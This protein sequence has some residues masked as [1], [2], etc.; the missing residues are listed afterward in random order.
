MDK[1]VLDKLLNS[2]KDDKAKGKKAVKQKSYREAISSFYQVLQTTEYLIQ[3][4]DPELQAR[5]E[6]FIQEHQVSSHMEVAVCFLN[7]KMWK[8]TIYHCQQT[9][10]LLE[11]YPAK[12]NTV[13]I[14]AYRT[15]ARAA[16]E[17]GEFELAENSLKKILELKP[18]DAEIESLVNQAQ[19]K[20]EESNKNEERSRSGQSV[21]RE[22]IEATLGFFF[23]RL[24]F[25]VGEKFSQYFEF[26]QLSDPTDAPDAPKKGRGC[27]ATRDIPPCTTL[28]IDR[29]I[30]FPSDRCFDLVDQI[31]RSPKLR[32]VYEKLYPNDE[33]PLVANLTN[34][35]KERMN[36]LR[37]NLD[38]DIRLRLL[39]PEMYD[40]QLTER[41]LQRVVLNS[42]GSDEMEY[43]Y[44]HLSYFNHSCD[45]NALAYHKG[46]MCL[47]KSIKP[48]KKGEEICIMYMDFNDSQWIRN[49]K[50]REHNFQCG[51]KRCAGLGEWR[52]KSILIQG[53]KCPV[54]KGTI[55]PDDNGDFACYRGC[56]DITKFKV[57]YKILD[58]NAA[59]DKLSPI[60]DKK[61]DSDVFPDDLEEEITKILKNSK[62]AGLTASLEE[63]QAFADKTFAPLHPTKA[64]VL[65]LLA[66]CYYTEGKSEEFNKTYYQIIEF[67]KVLHSRK[68][69][70]DIYRLVKKLCVE[71]KAEITDQLLEP[72]IYFG[73]TPE[74]MRS[75][76]EE[77][78][79]R[80]A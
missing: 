59:L 32:K 51:C 16:M 41:I 76:L 33:V 66:F 69:E 73:F 3:D 20:K 47:L 5:K 15:Q 44:A 57:E 43:L 48:I 28:L 6:E 49:I 10:Q 23:G 61:P 2:I 71:L 34:E 27:V 14:K 17:Y 72:F 46:D 21:N 30:Q 35:Y 58:Y 70:D 18:G 45:P 7:L 55:A 42:F 56:Y 25:E 65:P 68:L 63:L 8:E 39:R 54:C 29:S 67:S 24:K 4:K 9:I 50:L 26:V 74:E 62:K 22:M 64:L 75:T 13:L 19:R 12:E 77:E 38:D 31:H 1:A 37:E 78:K 80:S 36:L 40:R 11:K 53:I 52:D 79:K 60:H